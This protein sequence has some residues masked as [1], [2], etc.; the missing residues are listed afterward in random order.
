M[1]TLKTWHLPEEQSLEVFLVLQFVLQHY[2]L[3]KEE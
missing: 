1:G 3:F 2:K